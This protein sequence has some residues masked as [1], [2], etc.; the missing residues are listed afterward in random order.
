MTR[1]ERLQVLVEKDPDPLDDF[2]NSDAWRA[3][4]ASG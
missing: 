1:Y 2:P 3:R 4:H